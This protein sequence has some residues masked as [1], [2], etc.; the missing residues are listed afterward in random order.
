MLATAGNFTM[1]DLDSVLTQ[2]VFIALNIQKAPTAVATARYVHAQNICEQSAGVNVLI[3]LSE[4]T[5]AK[6][7]SGQL[8]EILL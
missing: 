4:E 7:Q 3:G 8:T 5:V 2:P 6:I 1:D